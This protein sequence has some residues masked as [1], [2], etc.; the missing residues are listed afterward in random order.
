MAN[1]DAFV[2]VSSYCNWGMHTEL[3]NDIDYLYHEWKD[4]PAMIVTYSGHSGP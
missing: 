1:W 4:K 2:F 3:K